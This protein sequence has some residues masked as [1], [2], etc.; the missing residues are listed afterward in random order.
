M[1]LT[2]VGFGIGGLISP[3][4]AQWL[5]SSYGWRQAY[6]VLGLITLISIV[7]LAQFMK[8][9]P[10]RVGL[11]PYGEDGDVEDKQSLASAAE[12]LS[13]TQ[14]IKTSRF[15]LFGATL[16]CFMFCFQVVIVHIAPHAA[17]IGLSA[18]VAASII[19]IYAATSLIGRLSTG[20]ISDRIG[21]RPAL[22]ACLVTVALALIWLVFA[23]EIWMLYVFAVILGVACGGIFPL[24]NLIPAEL[25]GLKFLGIILATV[26][27]LGT[28]GGAIGAPL[29]GFIYDA[30]GS[31]QL[32]FLICVILCALAVAISLILLRSTGRGNVGATK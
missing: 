2:A 32:A 8:H 29:A 31:Y 9:S 19:S 18:A 1:G 10:Q 22:T 27:F 25:F 12:G 28:I 7:P 17:D 21:T 13:F 4:L 23:K 30:T 14:A 26:M 11:K 24:Q 16:F 5:I 15:W 20:F 6:I 3:L